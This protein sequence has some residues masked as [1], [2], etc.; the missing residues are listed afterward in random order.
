[1]M[2]GFQR[3]WDDG[4]PGF[5]LHSRDVGCPQDAGDVDE[6]RGVRNVPPDA[7]SVINLIVTSVASMQRSYLGPKPCRRKMDSQR[8][9][10]G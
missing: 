7:D 4:V 6:Q 5:V 8:R 2:D 10:E 3:V 9:R 1:M